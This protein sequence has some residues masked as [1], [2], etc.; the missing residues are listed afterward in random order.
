[1]K[2]RSI[3]FRDEEIFKK[4]ESECYTDTLVY[5]CFPAA[6]YKYF[7]RLRKIYSDYKF[8]GLDKDTAAK[9]KAGI[10]A[11]YRQDAERDGLIGKVYAEY[12][13]NIR[14]AGTLRSEIDKAKTVEDKL[15]YALECIEAMTG[16]AGFA[17]R[18][19]NALHNEADTADRS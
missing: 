11:D 8:G 16:E 3:N 1:M 6:E 2:S 13:E 19:L 4:L 17:R 7:S 14:K 12:Q 15:R 9:R 10:Y 5:D 18:N